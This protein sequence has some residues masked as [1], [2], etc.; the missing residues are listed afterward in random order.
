[1]AFHCP[2]C[3]GSMVFDVASQQMS[4]QHC[5]S[6]C[7]PQNFV[8]REQGIDAGAAAEQ[9]GMARFTCQ[10]CGAE[11]EGTDDSL[12][13]FCPYCGGQSMV[14]GTAGTSEVEYLIPFSVDKTRC[15]ELYAG[16]TKKVRYLPKELRDANYIQKFTG[17]Y[18]PF[19]HYDI[20]FGEASVTGTKKVEHHSRYDVINH[21]SIDAHVNARYDRGATFDASRYLDDEVSARTQPFELDNERAFN[22]AYLAGFY[23]DVSTVKPDLYIE[24][25]QEQAVDDVVESIAE[26]EKETN[27]IAVSRATAEVEATT[28]GHHAALL[29]MWFLTWRKDDRVAYAVINGQT[30][31]VVSDLPLDQRSFWLGSAIISVVIFVIFELLFQPTP[32]VTSLISLA[33]AFAMALGI[34]SSAKHEVNKHRHAFDKGWRSDD[35]AEESESDKAR[36]KKAKKR[37][38]SLA[39]I[40]VVAA[41]VLIS[42]LLVAAGF[43][44][45]GG[46]GMLLSALRFVFPVLA[47]LCAI[48]TTVNVL[49]WNKEAKNTHAVIAIVILLVTVLLNSAVVLISPINDGYYYLGDAICIVGLVAASVEMIRIYNR[50]TTRP[51]PKL[52]DREE[53]Q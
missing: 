20:D 1:M 37:K 14:R 26:R 43:V 52:F 23:A 44:L 51:L 36:K 6:T 24:D 34:R 4:C 28:V 42:C 33:A 35:A 3:N 17:I 13:G 39:V 50:A 30:G 21:Y 9:A 19:Y 47:L 12:I 5:G 27:G 53:V 32:M 18:M 48:V 31:K 22:P 40:I 38:E 41:S 10:N 8:V 16:Y 49:M 46:G 15:M 11:L 25:A 29:P 2:N 45:G 7:D